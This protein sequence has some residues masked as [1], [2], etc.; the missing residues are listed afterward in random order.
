MSGDNYTDRA[1]LR[2]RF[3]AGPDKLAA[4][5]RLW[6]GRTGE[7][8][9][10]AAL[11]LAELAGDE[12]VLDAGCGNGVYETEL[13]RRRHR[14]PVVALDLSLGM[15]PTVVGDIANLPFPDQAF[16]VV[17]AMHMLY[18][19]PSIPKAAAELRRVLK[20]GGTLLAA[21]NGQKHTQEIHELVDHAAE[22]VTGRPRTRR[23][24]SFTLENGAG[25]LET[26]FADVRRIELT[27]T[28]PV[29]KEA[30]VDYIASAEP[31][32]C[33]VEPGAQHEAFMNVVRMTAGVTHVTSGAGLF[34]AR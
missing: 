4:R 14:G 2:E 7:S 9:V 29:T 3:Y 8:F 34:I 17:L 12:V 33:G 19:V 5:Q 24:L 25:L 6:A 20:R 22:A 32:N 27:K 15:R 21:T 1:A 10:V 11:D 23:Q 30:V 26:A 31:E 28:V 13:R 16:D 18:H